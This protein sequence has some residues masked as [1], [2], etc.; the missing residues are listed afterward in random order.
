MFATSYQSIRPTLVLQSAWLQGCR[1]YRLARLDLYNRY[2]SCCR[3]PDIMYL[4]GAYNAN[5]IDDN[6]AYLK[7]R[8][9]IKEMVYHTLSNPRVIGF[10]E[11]ATKEYR[12]GGL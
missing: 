9:I 5:S 10:D 4:L 6:E 2:I 7:I 1:R 3:F 12:N 8:Y 11:N